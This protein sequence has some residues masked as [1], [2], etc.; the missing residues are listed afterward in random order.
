M[1]LERLRHK[2]YAEY[3]D[4]APGPQSGD[5]GSLMTRLRFSITS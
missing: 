3:D 2:V 4:I 1:G 5:R